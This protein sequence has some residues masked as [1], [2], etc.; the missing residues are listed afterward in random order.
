MKVK[1][2][3]YDT[4]SRFTYSIKPAAGSKLKFCDCIGKIY[5]RVCFCTGNN[6]G[7]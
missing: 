7:T 1:V 6:N 4:L 5:I 2:K 3:V